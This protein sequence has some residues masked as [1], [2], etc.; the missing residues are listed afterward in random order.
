MVDTNKRKTYK[1]AVLFNANKVYD[2][3]VIEGIGRY[4][5][6]SKHNWDIFIQ[7][8]FVTDKSTVR[9]W[10][11][12]GII[13]DYDD[14]E[15]I[16]LLS[17]RKIPIVGVG[18]SFIDESQYPDVP[19]VA[20]DHG[21]VMEKAVDH[22]RNKG[23]ENF[24]FYGL[25]NIEEKKWAIERENHF[26]RIM[27]EF[28][29]T[30]SIYRGHKTDSRS[31]QYNINRLTDWIHML[32]KTTGIIA[33]TDARARHVLQAC[34]NSGIIV[35]DELSIIGVDNERVAQHLTKIG[36]SSVNHSAKTMGYE[37][38]K[39]LEMVLDGEAP[40]RK[41]VI[42]PANK[43][44]SRQSTDYLSINDPYVVKAM[45]YI[46]THI[47][48]GIK[49]YHVLDEVKLSRS[50]LEVRFKKEIGNTIHNEIHNERIKLTCS[51]LA[52]QHL[53]ISELY[54]DCGYPSLQYMYSVFTKEKG[55]TP[56]EYRE[57]IKEKKWSC[58]D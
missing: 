46:R 57:K 31:W 44:Y 43:V 34:E 38:A 29:Y 27:G 12:D 18:S 14:A 40:S 52:N 3:D 45:H 6:N 11:G 42:V 5:R 10:H 20:T 37:A 26:K 22:L 7:D 8:E 50:N 28:G 53:P 48:N 4:L 36:L 2:R 9:S 30:H 16:H 19:Y 58:T 17:D 35:P 15:L 24:A 41:R 33:V 49:V 32:P 54:A 13:A 25:P 1:I 47:R 55:M 51:L 56:K 23:I 39:M 21:S